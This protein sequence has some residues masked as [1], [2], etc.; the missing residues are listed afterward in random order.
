MSVPRTASSMRRTP[1]PVR[2][3][4]S[5]AWFHDSATKE[6]AADELGGKIL[7]ALKRQGMEIDSRQM[8]ASTKGQFGEENVNILRQLAK[9]IGGLAEAEVGDRV[10]FVLPGQSRDISEVLEGAQNAARV[11]QQVDDGISAVAGG[12]HGL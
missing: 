3:D 2:F 9:K 11:R 4:V 7:S 6:M 5:S 1:V 10:S 12:D 8:S